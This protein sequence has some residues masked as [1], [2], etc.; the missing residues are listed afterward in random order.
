MID[1]PSDQ[2]GGLPRLP[3]GAELPERGE[4]WGV[5]VH[6]WGVHHDRDRR[7]AVRP[8]RNHRHLA[9][10]MEINQHKDMVRDVLGVGHGDKNSPNFWNRTSL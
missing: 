3:S 9:V 1:L 8:L 6:H 2:V 4:Q 7:Q 5:L 10:S